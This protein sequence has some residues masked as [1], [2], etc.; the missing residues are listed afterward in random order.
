MD[1]PSNLAGSREFVALVAILVI[2]VCGWLFLNQP[3]NA[4]V[5]PAANAQTIMVWP[6]SAKDKQLDVG[7]EYDTTKVT[8]ELIAGKR[9]QRITNV[10]RAELHFWP[11][12][13]EINTGT[14]VI[15]CPGG[16]FYILA[17]D[18]EGTEI[19]KWLNSIGVNAFILKYR[20]PTA[21]DDDPAMAPTEDLQRAIA[22][23]RHNAANWNLKTDRIGTLGFSAGGNVIANAAFT[24]DRYDAVDEVDEQSARADFIVPVYGARMVAKEGG[25]RNGMTLDKSAPTAFIVHAVDDMV[26]VHNAIELSEL[27]SKAGVPFQCHIFD[28]GGHGYGARYVEGVP[29]TDWPR[30]CEAW[31]RKNGWLEK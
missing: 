8:G 11:A 25:L 6:E 9:V 29:V 4:N 19:A 18:L 3:I 5:E 26:P 23:V 2:A 30:L 1:T 10:S 22:L 13:T 14:S 15:I 27:Y 31:M 12:E 16:G 7:A 24:S 21:K 17:W 20:V 28:T